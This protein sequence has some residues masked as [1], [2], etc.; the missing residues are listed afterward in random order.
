MFQKTN[1][2]EK[3]PSNAAAETGEKQLQKG[4]SLPAVTPA[5]L[6]AV[7]EEPLQGNFEPVQKVEEEEPLQGKF[8]TVQKA[9]EEEPLQGKFEPIQKVEEEEPLQG[10]FE[11]VQKA[12]EEEPLQGKFE[13]VQKAAPEEEL[14]MKADPIQ[15][16]SPE[17]ELPAQA[18]F[19]PIQKAEEEEP[20]Q[21][22]FKAV[23]RKA[24]NTAPFQLKKNISR[25]HPVQRQEA[26]KAPNRTGMPDTLKSG[27]E[28]LS[29]FSMSDVKVHYNSDKPK[30]LQ[31]LAYAQGTD[32]HIAPGQEQ[33][34]PHEAWHVAQQKQGRVQPTIQMK[35]GTP[36][37]DDAGLE[38]EADVMGAKAMATG[39]AALGDAMQKKEL[40]SSQTAQLR[41]NTNLLTGRHT[42]QRRTVQKKETVQR[43]PEL[44]EMDMAELDAIPTRGR[45][46][47]VSEEAPAT[48]PR[49]GPVFHAR[50][51]GRARSQAVTEAPV[52]LQW[53]TD[54]IGIIRM[55]ENA[56]TVLSGVNWDAKA[57]GGDNADTAITVGGAVGG[58]TGA[59]GSITNKAK[60][61]ADVGETAMG[62]AGHVVASVGSS[63]GALISSVKAIKLAYEESEQTEAGVGGSVQAAGALLTALKAG[64]EAAASVQRFVSGSVAPGIMAAIPGLGIAIAACEVITNAYTAYNAQQSEADMEGVS[65]EF[66]LALT[67]LIG[68]PEDKKS[69]FAEEKR[70]KM[71]NRV[72]YLRLKPGLFETL[73]EVKADTTGKKEPNFR[74]KHGI[75]AE[76][77]FDALYTAIKNYE[78]GSKMQEINQKRKVQGARNILASV[79]RIAGEIAKFFPADGGITA[80][81][82]VGTSAAIGAA[83]SVAKLVQGLAREGTIGGGD[84]SRSKS[85]KH[86]EY[87]NHTRSIYQYLDSVPKPVTRIHEGKVTAGKQLVT[88]TGAN[89]SS[90]Y[91]VDYTNSKAVQGQV[92]GIVDAMK[93]G[94]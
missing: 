28:S 82:L 57:P 39:T 14:Q 50:P 10:K 1:V 33:H 70:G 19:D 32:I 3:A 85:S 25:E 67:N 48:R 15:K 40:P 78:L 64:F 54:N 73:D 4:M 59:A 7:E 37:N 93:K 30:Q 35:E 52:D 9:E 22:K 6:A 44:G 12:E 79:I 83:Q 11:T 62:A 60:G 21:G 27:V 91:Q 69:L 16:A 56:G 72:E 43:N 86:K 26:F 75:P 87:L 90:L 81:V 8:E 45:S 71:F 92:D 76:V 20:L 34:L 24:A 74:R 68:I 94:R 53:K 65:G 84:T 38:H 66:R 89:T 42:A 49:S 47:A 2:Q 36:V 88:A 29:G 80:G 23:Q 61:A 31:A 63:I 58:V 46:V 51:G 5:Q 13:T 55:I 17:E 18:K 77:S 41:F